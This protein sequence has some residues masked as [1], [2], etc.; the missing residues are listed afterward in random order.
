M[1][2]RSS[3]T[4][5][6]QQYGYPSAP[7]PDASTSGSGHGHRYQPNYYQSYSST[8]AYS[9]QWSYQY[10][11]QPNTVSSTGQAPTGQPNGQPYPSS[12]SA[13]AYSYS[14]PSGSYYAP[15]QPPTTH[16]NTNAYSQQS[17]GQ[18]APQPQYTPAQYQTY[19]QYT[20][21][22]YTGYAQT[23]A[24][25]RPASVSA[26]QDPQDNALYMREPSYSNSRSHTPST[27]GLRWQRPYVGP[28]A[29]RASSSQSR[30]TSQSAVALP[31][32]GS[33]ETTPALDA[34]PSVDFMAAPT[35]PA[36]PSMT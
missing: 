22:V 21:G 11:S 31:P 25:Q 36:M 20:P 28:K 4:R 26:F 3:L 1:E 23:G 33:H 17:P 5:P 15:S 16:Q 29:S 18:Y 8:Q 24:D 12:Y 10:A 30:S 19:S 7:A 34:V 32:Q 2:V 6:Q 14:Y 13:G 9:G 27:Q 35:L